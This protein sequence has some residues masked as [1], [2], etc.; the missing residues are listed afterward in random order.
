MSSHAIMLYKYVGLFWHWI[1]CPKRCMEYCSTEYT[2]HHFPNPAWALLC[3]WIGNEDNISILCFTHVRLHPPKH[4]EDAT[5]WW[6][7]LA[8]LSIRTVGEDYRT[9]QELWDRAI[10]PTL[11]LLLFFLPFSTSLSC[12]GYV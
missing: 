2:N 9:R 3:N 11:T 6:H 7:L 10:S 4:K 5:R 8:F 1:I 12:W